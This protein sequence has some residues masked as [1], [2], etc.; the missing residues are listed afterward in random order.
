MDEFR[1]TLSPLFLCAWSQ[2]DFAAGS[3][4]ASRPRPTQVVVVWCGAVCAGVEAHLAKESNPRLLVEAAAMGVIG[5][6]AA[7]VFAWALQ[8]CEHLFLTL[9]AGYRPPALPG[10]GG[11]LAQ[12]IGPHGLWL[13]P[14]VTTLGGL[15]SGLLVYTFA[16]E[17]EGHGTDTVVKAFHRTAGFI[18]ARVSPLKLVAS[19]ITIGSGGAAG[20]EGPTALIGAGI[21]STYATV[22]GHRRDEER[23]LLVLMGMAAGLSAIFRSPIGAAFFA[24]EVLYASMEFES[25]ALLYTMLASIV[26]YG[27]NGFFVGWQPLFNFPAGQTRLG[28]LNYA[29]LGVLGCASGLIATLLPMVFYRLRDGFRTLPFP[30]ALNPAIGGLGVG[31]IALK[32]PQVLGGGYG[33]IQEAMDGRLAV[34]LLAI[35][36]FLKILAFALTVSSGGSGGVFAPALFVG[37]MLGGLLSSLVHLPAAIFVVVGMVAVFGAAARVPIAALVMVTEMTGGYQLLP[38]AGF[39]VLL[40]YLV[41]TQLSSRLK[42]NSLYEAQVLGRFQTPARYV[43]NVQLALSVLG[44]GKVPKGAK[45]G[46]LDLVALL[47]SGMPVNL[48]GRRQLKVGVLH[49]ESDLVGKTIQDCYAM[50][51]DATLEIFAILRNGHA[52]LPK[53]ETRLQKDD[54]LLV[55][56]S[57]RA[58]TLMARH[59]RPVKR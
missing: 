9:L 7:Q 18:R 45:I 13:I 15:L 19:A 46:H 53:P 14:L 56:E 4:D 55:I 59:L 23:S 51:K 35:L 32:F 8:S 57:G 29:W 52:L 11:I 41:Q 33:W 30:P 21:G 26:A 2:L 25:G 28:L 16:P 6:L 5:A 22:F 34:Q 3:R 27:I 31:L 50:A 40:S 12:E 36:I 54:R 38:A 39:A 24:V 48:P 1:E 42:Y 58:E 49:A 47:D 37:A 44:K 17:A 20:R 43:E 10:E